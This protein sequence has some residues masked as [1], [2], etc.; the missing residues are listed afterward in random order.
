MTGDS[1][2]A[3]SG[4]DV[5]VTRGP[6][7][8][9]FR[10]QSDA[11]GRWRLI[12]DPGTGDYL[13]FASSLGRVPQRKRVTRTG[14]ETAFTVDL[15]LASAGAQQLARVEVRATKREAPATTLAGREASRGNAEQDV[16]GVYSALAP[17]DLGNPS[18]LAGV[19]PGLQTGP[20]GVSALG[21]SGA[22]TQYTLN[23][24]AGGGAE[25][26][27]GMSTFARVATTAWDVA[28][29]GFSGAQVDVSLFSGG[30]YRYNTVSVTAEAP[31]MQS[32]D[33]VGRALGQR[34]AL[35]DVNL[36]STGSIDRRDRFGYSVATRVR[37]RTSDAPSLNSA[38]PMALSAA[39]VAGDSARQVLGA[40]TALGVP[41]GEVRGT[42]RTDFQVATSI[43]RI[44][45]DEERYVS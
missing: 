7:R 14:S 1:G 19:L 3:L 36:A 22:Q 32:S 44:A 35:V 37:R 12:A 20:G 26:P 4:A 39:G 13:V 15:V 23:G 25:V 9:V 5:I 10:T 38:T 34:S 17:T 24:M 41:V 11:A 33:A 40:V 18:A 30:V 8:T 43:G 2:A 31:G 16:D 45:Y 29:G 27:R 21:L 28:R 42:Q 6:D